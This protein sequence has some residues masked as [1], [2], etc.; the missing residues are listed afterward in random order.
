MTLGY[1]L[2]FL[3]WSGR[4]APTIAITSLFPYRSFCFSCCS[5]NI[6]LIYPLCNGAAHKHTV[7]IYADCR[8]RSR[9]NAAS[10]EF[11]ARNEWRKIGR[12]SNSIISNATQIVSIAAAAASSASWHWHWQRASRAA[13]RAHDA[14]VPTDQLTDE[15]VL[16]A[17]AHL[18]LRTT[19]T[20][21]RSLPRGA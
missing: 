14:T 16:S 1:Y 15:R 18:F 13:K 5:V 17:V 9:R 7:V 4:A 10:S 11:C 2:T 6:R 21:V 20:L 8:T 12:S 3:H 19:W